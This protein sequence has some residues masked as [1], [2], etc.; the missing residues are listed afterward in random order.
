LGNIYGSKSIT[1]QGDGNLV[2]VGTVDK[3]ACSKSIT[4]QGDGN[5]KTISSGALLEKSSKSITPQ[6]DGNL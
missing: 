2:S 6:G 3:T 5:I 4:P 1:P